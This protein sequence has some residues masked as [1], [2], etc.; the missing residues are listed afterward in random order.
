MKEILFEI[1]KIFVMIILGG[2]FI[3]N[4]IVRYKR[5]EYFICGVEIMLAVYEAALICR[6]LFL[7]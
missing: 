2:Y 6:E 7:M 4:A 5:E 3:K 1:L